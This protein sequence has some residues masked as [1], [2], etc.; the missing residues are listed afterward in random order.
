MLKSQCYK[1][2]T[3]LYKL[4]V[5]VFLHVYMKVSL[6]DKTYED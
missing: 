6:E 5:V 3:D 1:C 2:L 4:H